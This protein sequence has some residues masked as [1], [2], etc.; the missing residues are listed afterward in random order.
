METDMETTELRL[1]LDRLQTTQNE[2][3]IRVMFDRTDGRP[4]AE[5]FL[6]PSIAASPARL[7]N[8]LLDKGA[9]LPPRKEAI[10]LLETAIATIP[11]KAGHLLDG[12]GWH[13]SIPTMCFVLPDE[14]I[15]DVTDIVT[16]SSRAKADCVAKGLAGT[17]EA[18]KAGVASPLS[19]SGVAGLALLTVLAAPLLKFAALSENFVINVFGNS[20]AGKTS[21][22]LAASS[23]FGDPSAIPSWNASTTGLAQWTAANSDLPLIPDDAETASE[24]PSDR[25]KKLHALTHLLTGKRSKKYARGVSGPDQLQVADF[26]SLVLSSSPA[27][28]E[29]ATSRTDGDRVRWFD[30]PVSHGND[31]GIWAPYDGGAQRTDTATLSKNLVEAARRNH[32]HAGRAYLRYLAANQSTLSN[33]IEKHTKR[34][35]ET[36][37]NNADSVE[38]RVARKFGLLY[39]AGM[40]ARK[41]GI[42]PWTKDDV[43]GI[44]TFGYRSA[45]ATAFGGAFDKARAISGLPSQINDRALFPR[46]EEESLAKAK[47][48][49]GALGYVWKSKDRI[50][51]RLSGLYHML[52]T[53]G[54]GSPSPS[55]V[56]ALLTHLRTEGALI[57]G[58]GVHPTRDIRIGSSRMKLLEFRLKRLGEVLMV[59]APAKSENIAK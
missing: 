58:H 17:T 54:A 43:M 47:V 8:Q 35:L 53:V 30:I 50:F 22:N 49:P 27:S 10:A 19:R 18:W 56:S 4:R 7:Y 15:G 21:G 38:G 23:V 45:L 44:A 39:S 9:A 1:S 24:D 16:M 3:V 40:L 34:F 57:K 32:G 37:A 14:I 28:I 51:I 20:S 13:G 36:S 59:N 12:P 33:S 55:D 31:G 52:G 6:K 48:R 26:R 2:D 42:L 29:Q 11:A 41:A 5:L 46:I 25:L